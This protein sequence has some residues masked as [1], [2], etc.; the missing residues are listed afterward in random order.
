MNLGILR[1]ATLTKLLYNPSESTTIRIEVREQ[2]W[3]DLQSFKSRMALENR[4]R[5]T[6]NAVVLVGKEKNG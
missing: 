5:N 4:K 6:K 3:N 2:R 1:T